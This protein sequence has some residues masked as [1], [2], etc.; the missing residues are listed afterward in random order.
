LNLE[1]VKAY[2]VTSGNKEERSDDQEKKC[3]GVAGILG[4]HHKYRA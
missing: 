2:L 4:E 1:P 3:D